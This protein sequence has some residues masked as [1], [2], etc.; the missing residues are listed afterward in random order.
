MFFLLI[1]FGTKR[2]KLQFDII[3]NNEDI[4]LESFIQIF[5]MASTH[6]SKNLAI[7]KYNQLVLNQ[8]RYYGE[9]F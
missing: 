1:M 3:R 8:P 7:P 5:G 9:G 4:V 6:L 2:K